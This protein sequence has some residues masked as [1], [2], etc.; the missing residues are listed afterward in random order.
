VYWLLSL[1]ALIVVTWVGIAA[2][3][4]EVVRVL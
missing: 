4:V 1:I 2:I 3:A